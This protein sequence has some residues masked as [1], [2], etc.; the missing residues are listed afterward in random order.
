MQLHDG[1][2]GVRSVEVGDVVQRRDAFDLIAGDGVQR[3]DGRTEQGLRLRQG[4]VQGH[5][6]ATPRRAGRLPRHGRWLPHALL[7]VIRRAVI[8][9]RFHRGGSRA[10]GG[11]AAGCGGVGRE[12]H[13]DVHGPPRSKRLCLFFGQLHRN[14][15]GSSCL[16]VGHRRSPLSPNNKGRAVVAWHAP[17]SHRSQSSRFRPGTAPGRN[18]RLHEPDHSPA[19]MPTERLSDSGIGTGGRSESGR[20]SLESHTSRSGAF[21]MFAKIAATSFSFSV[22]LTSS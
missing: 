2:H 21:R 12:P 19:P 18:L 6:G 20:C 7:P 8:P 13:H 4:A 16:I 9:G 1:G 10:H 5:D 17:C 14:G 22:C 11:A 3:H 15:N